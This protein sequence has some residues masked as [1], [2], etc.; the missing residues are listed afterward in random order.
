MEMS[1]KLFVCLTLSL[2][3]LLWSTPAEAQRFRWWKDD[4]FVKELSLT[5]DQTTRIEG[6]FQAAQP[7]LRAQ[8]RALSMLEDELSKLVQEARV[9]ESEVDHFV[10]KVES[11]RADL[12]K[13]RMMM[14]YRIRRILSS[15]QHAK[16]QA[17]FEQR[18]KEREKERRG[19]G[20][21]QK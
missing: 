9:E 20:R 8:Q 1:R 3:T 21:G 14:I 4:R 5:P 12:A 19:K 6:V 10:G 11:A 18:E 13:T 17:L 16:L 7:A 2:L 15:D